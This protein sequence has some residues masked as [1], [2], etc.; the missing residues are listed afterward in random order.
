MIRKWLC[1]TLICLLLIA[2]SPLLISAQ[3]NTDKTAPSI[4]KVK[5]TVIKRRKVFRE[6]VNV[7]ML[8]GTQLKGYIS[9]AGEDSFELTDSNTK[10]V[11]SIAYRNVA[12]VKKDG[13]KGDKIALWIIGGAAAAGAVVLGSFLLRRS[14]N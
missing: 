4:V 8:N 3:T 1:F 14:R 7:E 9:Q 5:R 12:Q 6:P 2:A 11:T 10:Q 13:A